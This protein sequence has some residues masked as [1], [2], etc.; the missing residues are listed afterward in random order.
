MTRPPY[1]VRAFR[2]AL[3]FQHR[4]PPLVFLHLPKTA[5]TTLN[6]IIQRQFPAE[7]QHFVRASHDP[8]QRDAFAALPQAYRHSIRL[9]RGHQAFG[10]HE[11]MAPGAR[12]VTFLRDP[13]ARVISHYH[14][15]KPGQLPQ[16]ADVARKKMSLADYAAST[17]TAEVENG[18][19]RW[20]A[21]VW[22]DRP[23]V[24]ADYQQAVRNIDE[25][26]DAVGI[27]ERFDESLVQIA[28]RYGWVRLA[29]R[30][31]NVAAPRP[32]ESEEA[33]AIIRQRNALDLRLYDYAVQRHE[34][35]PLV[36]RAT[37][38]AGAVA[39]RGVNQLW[40]TFRSDDARD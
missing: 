9:L 12:Y 15:V 3:R 20:I 2:T 39:L 30:K 1:L 35:L 17:I 14:Y 28:A 7:R 34:A 21:G 11:G 38:S 33:V 29:Y 6:R 31:A 4:G 16:F 37:R 24:E 27:T 32:P 13:V 10:L 8:A 26:F 5:G 19:T 25:H 36:A 23:L 18:Q 22:S 40:G